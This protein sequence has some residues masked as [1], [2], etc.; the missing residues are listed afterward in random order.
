[1]TNLLPQILCLQ[2]SVHIIHWHCFQ[3]SYAYTHLARFWENA[4]FVGVDQITYKNCKKSNWMQVNKILLTRDLP[5]QFP[6]VFVRSFQWNQTT[7]R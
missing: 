3:E 5:E 1:M 2:T 7:M 4:K 6:S